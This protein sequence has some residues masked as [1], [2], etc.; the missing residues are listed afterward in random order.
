L[1]FDVLL[2]KKGQ[3][4]TDYKERTIYL[5]IRAKYL[6][7]IEKKSKNGIDASQQAKP[8][9]RGACDDCNACGENFWCMVV[10]LVVA[11]SNL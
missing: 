6:F 9:C 10:M 4:V 8:Y 5:T 1:N 7:T 3:T 2:D 11:M